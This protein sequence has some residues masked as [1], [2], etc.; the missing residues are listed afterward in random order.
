MPAK[1]RLSNLAV[2]A[3]LAL[4]ACG[5]TAWQPSPSDRLVFIG[6]YTGEKTGSKGIYA[7]RFDDASGTLTPLGLK[8]ETTSPSFLTLSPNHKV[9]YA[10]NEVGNYKGEKAGSV[11]SYT[12]DA[13][14]G[15]L[16]S[17]GTTLS[18]GGAD[19]C[20]LQCDR[21]GR[22]LA[23]ANYTGGNF[24]LFPIGANGAL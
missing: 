13:A 7:F 9:L 18:T 19:P 24:A 17:L 23:V 8:A 20:H 2:A 5:A 4:A 14:T 22:A 3:V 12:V 16:T 21:T 10:V 11:T 1:T 15:A 6:T